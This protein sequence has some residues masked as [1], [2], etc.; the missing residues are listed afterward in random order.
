MQKELK[1]LKEHSFV[2]KF[3]KATSHILTEKKLAEFLENEKRMLSE[4][5]TLKAERDQKHLDFNKHL[6][7]EKELL[8]EKIATLENKY[9][10]SDT[11]RN[12]LLF[13]IEKEK[14]K[15]NLDKDHLLQQKKELE[16]DR[17][18]LAKKAE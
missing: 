16:E 18:R 10:E 9:R 6:E 13:E 12:A 1:Q 5:E 4:I 8:K 3:G 11:K 17:E 7:S 15:W 2:E 14:A